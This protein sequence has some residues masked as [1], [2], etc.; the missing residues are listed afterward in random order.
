MISIFGAILTVAMTAASFAQET[1]ETASEAQNTASEG[2]A[3]TSAEARPWMSTPWPVLDVAGHA[4]SEVVVKESLT[5]ICT[6]GGAKSEAI[7]PLRTRYL[8]L[9]GQLPRTDLLRVGTTLDRTVQQLHTLMARP[10][11][12][13]PFAG[14]LGLA[15]LSSRD[16]F[17]LTLAD[18]L[19]TYAR[20]STAA[21]LQAE[22]HCSIIIANARAPR[23][24]LDHQLDR[25]VT[26]AYLHALHSPIRL[27]AWANEGVATAVAWSRAAPGSGRGR[28]EAIAEVRDELDLSEMLD[29]GYE[30]GSWNAT[31]HEEA[32]AGLLMERLM[33]ERP[34]QLREWILAVKQGAPWREAFAAHF[35]DSPEAMAAWVTQ[36]F[37]VN[38]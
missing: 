18:A 12:E 10:D 9:R 37:K 26:H 13:R 1:A 30:D 2:L 8:L 14:R 29:M 36:Y 4:S 11:D 3:T 31:E 16:E 35:N 27:P 22:G 5:S 28:A 7:K 33:L 24:L 21:V 19:S 25:T 20:P 34:A 23:G 15:L 38:D 17:V 6:K 32:K